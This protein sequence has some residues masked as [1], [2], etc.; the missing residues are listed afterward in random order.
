[1][2]RRFESLKAP[3]SCRS[4]KLLDRDVI[5]PLTFIKSLILSV[6]QFRCVSVINQSISHGD[7]TQVR[8]LKSKLC[9][10]TKIKCAENLV[11]DKMM[12][13]RSSSVRV[14]IIDTRQVQ[15]PQVQQAKR[16]SHPRPC[17]TCLQ[18][19][20]LRHRRR[21]ADAAGD[22]AC[23]AEAF[24]HLIRVVPVTYCQTWSAPTCIHLWSF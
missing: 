8:R 2:Q 22:D 12:R 21:A 7:V 11:G 1:M 10:I 15:H 16:S 14:V 23:H 3:R 19:T 4:K 5:K 18:R 13:R 17:L 9:C 24:W 6:N 20:A